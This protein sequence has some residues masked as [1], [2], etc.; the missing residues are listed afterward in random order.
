MISDETPEETKKQTKVSISDKLL[1]ELNNGIK[2][3]DCVA[4]IGRALPNSI[5]DFVDKNEKLSHRSLIFRDTTH[6]VRVHFFKNNIHRIKQIEEGQIYKIIHPKVTG[7]NH[8]YTNINFDVIIESLTKIVK[9]EEN[10]SIPRLPLLNITEI[11]EIDVGMQ[12]K[13]VDIQ[14]IITNISEIETA[15]DET[16]RKRTV[17]VQGKDGVRADMIFWGIV[18]D[19]LKFQ[20]GELVVFKEV[21]VNVYKESLQFSVVNSSFWGKLPVVIV[22]TE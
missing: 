11:G 14:G 22:K 10:V 7:A 6:E 18:A 16:K 19:D 9:Q 13:L 17:W 4:I 5:R 12:G 20:E 1:G 2:P 21:L 3:S 8:K 15:A